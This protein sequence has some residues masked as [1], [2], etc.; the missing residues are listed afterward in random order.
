M[1]VFDYVECPCPLCGGTVEFQSKGAD[2]PWMGTY[3]GDDLP[4]AVAA[5][6]STGF[7]RDCDK[8]MVAVLSGTVTVTARARTEKDGRKER[9]EDEDDD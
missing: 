4:I 5:D 8:P 6:C 9:G 7:C 3:Q 1:G 2:H